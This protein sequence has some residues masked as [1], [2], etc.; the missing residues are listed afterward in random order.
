MINVIR[1]TTNKDFND[2]NAYSAE[3]KRWSQPWAQQP[4]ENGVK[5]YCMTEKITRYFT[6]CERQIIETELLN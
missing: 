4:T 3:I 5:S 1:K 6:I 2:Q